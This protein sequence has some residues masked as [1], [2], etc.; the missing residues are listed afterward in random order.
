MSDVKKLWL[1]QAF[2]I[3]ISGWEILHFQVVGYKGVLRFCNTKS[4]SAPRGQNV[5]GFHTGNV[6]FRWLHFRFLLDSYHII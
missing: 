3:S 1:Q 5:I 4:G 2:Y 6:N